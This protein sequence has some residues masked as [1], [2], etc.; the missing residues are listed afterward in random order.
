M[1]KILLANRAAYPTIGG[2][3]NSLRYIGRELLRVRHQIKIFSLQVSPNEPLRMEHEGIEILRIPYTPKRWPHMRQLELVK[4]VEHAVPRILGEYQPDAVWSRSAPMGLGIRRGGY[5]GPLLQIYS[6]N[7]KMNCQGLYLQT[8]GLPMK[9]RLMLLGLWPLHYLISS[10]LEKEL[11]LQS[12][13]VAFSENMRAQLLPG[14]PEAARSCRLIRP[15]VDC[16]VFS[17]ENGARFFDRI[18]EEHGLSRN[19]ALVL[20]VGRLSTCKHIAMLMDAVHLLKTNVKLLLVGN[21]PDEDYLRS[22]AQRIGLGDRV[23]FV[24]KQH[25]MLPGFYAMSRVLVLPTTTESFGQVYLESLAAG[26]P[27]IGFAGDGD[28]VLTATSEIIQDG[29]TG[30]VV[31]KVSASALA[32]KIDSILS[33]NDDDYAIMSQRARKDVLGRF[34]WQHFV[35]KA[36]ELSTL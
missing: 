5:E 35:T 18:E 36:L 17:P 24:G 15:G 30:G 32:E 19:E 33:L 9:R 4:T 11:A 29:K 34:S 14:F 3:E 20:Y 7:A 22:Y 13:A 8:H 28:R 31:K 23:A 16:D 10:K 12:T 2:V 6:T 21:G 1:M 27:A 26:T 25:K